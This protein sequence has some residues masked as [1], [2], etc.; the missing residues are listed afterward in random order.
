MRKTLIL[1]AAI[2]L[3]TACSSEPEMGSAGEIVLSRGEENLVDVQNKFAVEFFKNTNAILAEKNDKNTVVSPLNVEM[4]LSMTIDAHNGYVQESILKAYGADD[5]QQL[6]AFNKK[7]RLALPNI[8]PKVRC[9]LAYGFWQNS[10]SAIDIKE[11]LKTYYAADYTT[12]NFAKT[13]VRAAVNKWVEDHTDGKIKNLMNSD[14][15]DF[16]NF[17]AASTLIFKGQWQTRFDKTEKVNFTNQDGSKAAADMMSLNEDVLFGSTE[18]SYMCG[19]LMGDGKFEMDFILPR[20][21]DAK[22]YETY[23]EELDI[24]E[25]SRCINSFAER[26]MQIHLPKFSVEKRYNSEMEAA[27]KQSGIKTSSAMNHAVLV[28]V[29]ENGAEAYA[30][31]GET[32]LISG[33]GQVSSLHF[34]RPFV[35]LIRENGSGLILAIGQ[36]NDL[37][38]L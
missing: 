36:I 32:F 24:D 18:N 31:T 9:K 17:V 23:I 33:G 29:D 6:H 2:S 16:A 12:C 28:S 8:D 26:R 10:S 13:D 20:L 35:Y 14:V 1:M 15:P 37:R 4:S 19:L 30:A 11:I 25:I 27:L 34:N 21:D 38:K 22:T 7:V 3:L 5:S